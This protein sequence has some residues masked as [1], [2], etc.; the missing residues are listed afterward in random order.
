LAFH[1]PVAQGFLE[2]GIGLQKDGT[3]LGN[4]V[5]TW[6]IAQDG[7]HQRGAAAAT[8]NDEDGVVDMA[9]LGGF[10]LEGLRLAV[11]FD[12]GRV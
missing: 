1:I 7:E 12:F 5:N 10:N 4:G 2:G 9:F 6:M 8:A 11:L 3:F